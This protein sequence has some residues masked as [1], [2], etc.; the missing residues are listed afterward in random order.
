MRLV[1]LWLP[2]ADVAVLSVRNRV[3]HGGHYVPED[4]VRRRYQRGISNFFLLYQSLA[5]E[6]MFYDNRQSQAPILLAKGSGTIEQ[7]IDAETWRA[8]KTEAGIP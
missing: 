1:F 8:I 7:V 2:S 6:W 3:S 4:T 5:D